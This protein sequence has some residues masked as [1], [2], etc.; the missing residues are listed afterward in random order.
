LVGLWAG[1]CC[2]GDFLKVAGQ[3][4]TGRFS[5]VYHSL[6]GGRPRSNGKGTR[7]SPADRNTKTLLARQRPRSRLRAA[8]NAEGGRF[9][10][11]SHESQR[12]EFLH[13]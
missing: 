7:A 9:N 8:V 11:C 3:V 2:R 12:A 13:V 6:G 10:C 5:F 4:R 1:Q